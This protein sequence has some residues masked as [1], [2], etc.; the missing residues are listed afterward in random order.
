MSCSQF[1]LNYIA[2][3]NPAGSFSKTSFF[4]SCR[5][6]TGVKEMDYKVDRQ[7][8]LKGLKN[9]FFINIGSQPLEKTLSFAVNTEY[10]DALLNCVT[11]MK[12]LLFLQ[13]AEDEHVQNNKGYD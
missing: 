10:V 11:E 3:S 1:S 9:C 13:Q 2:R 12:L 4:C 5:D 7:T 8:T 6:I